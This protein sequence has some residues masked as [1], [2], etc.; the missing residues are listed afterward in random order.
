MTAPNYPLAT[1]TW[2]DA[3]QAAL[4]RIIQSNRFTMGKEV[5]RFEQQFADF[6]S[7][8]YAVMVNSGSSANLLMVAALFFTQK[9]ALKPGDEVIVPAVS[10]STTYTPLQQYGLHVKFVDIDAET[11]NYDLQALE[12]A[13]T[14]KTR[15]LF[16]VNL[17]GNPNDFA[18]I[19]QLILDKPIRLI[20]D[21]CESM[22]ATF[23][24]KQAGTFGEMGSYSSFFSHHISTIEGGMITVKDEELYHI[25][26]SLRSHG[27]TRHLP[28]HNKITGTKSDNVF[29]ESFKFILP[30]YNVRPCELNGALGQEQLK[31][32]PAIVSERRRNA[33]T[34]VSKFENHPLFS[35]QREL[36][37][38]S[39]FGF[40]LTLK[41]EA[42]LSR[43]VVLKAL[44]EARIDYR[45]I[46]AGNFT[47]N[48]VIQYFNYSIAGEL[49]NAEHV[50]KAGFFVG[51]HH[52]P[53]PELI[54]YLAKTLAPESLIQS[55]VM[56]VGAVN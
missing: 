10:W 26:L 56:P 31:K 47:K 33:E 44:D 40:A 28:K 53:I 30:G 55:V 27:W 3:E 36:G 43:E 14:D 6:M 48:P 52:Y 21:N 8:P 18:A 51:N 1:F 2:D 11:L 37:E 5:E 24:G 17:L 38:S 29:E 41:D 13:I 23:N 46:V 32:L 50:D 34:F 45:P 49:P 20:E 4:Q 12:A 15:L 9:N 16:C 39:W 35:I 19:Q 54:D 25:L 22:G 7:V 42:R